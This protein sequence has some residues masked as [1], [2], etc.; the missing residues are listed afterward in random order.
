[1]CNLQTFFFAMTISRTRYGSKSEHNLDLV[2]YSN[3]DPQR[4]FLKDSIRERL[5]TLESKL[6]AKLLHV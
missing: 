4:C 5:Q 2:Y 3:P 1:M 6:I